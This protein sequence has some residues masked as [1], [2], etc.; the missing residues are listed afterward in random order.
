MLK[1]KLG[2]LIRELK[3]LSPFVWVGVAGVAI[4][5]TL[6]YTHQDWRLYQQLDNEGLHAQGWVTDKDIVGG[7]NVNYA[8]RVGDKVY[9]GT[10]TGGYTNP[11]FPELS[12]DDPVLVY[13]LPRDPQVS[14][15]GDPALRVE[16]QHR[17][18]A[19]GLVLFVPL[20]LFAL[21]AELKSHGP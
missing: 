13:Y 8:F 16:D 15:L 6:L 17:W 12:P 14:G 4:I 3:A 11:S 20:F 5:G 18:E 10:G 2:I 19:W 21:R 7:K 1:E 9:R